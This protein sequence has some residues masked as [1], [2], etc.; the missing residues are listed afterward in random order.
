MVLQFVLIVCLAQTPAAASQLNEA[1]RLFAL[2]DVDA[3]LALTNRVIEID[4]K[5]RAAYSLRASLLERRSRYDDAA[6]DWT[7]VLELNPTDDYALKGRAR[8]H[9]KAGRVA[10]SLADF[11]AFVKQHPEQSRE[12][13][14]RGITCYYTGKFDEG[15]RQFESYQDFDSADF[16][17]A[18]WRFMCM[19]RSVGLEKARAEMLKIGDDRRVPLR[20][21]YELYLG[22]KS[23]DDVLSAAMKGDPDK[24]LRNRQL[25][26]AHLYLG[27]WFDLLDERAKALVHLNKATNDHPIDHYMWDVAR[28]HRDRLA[29]D[30]GPKR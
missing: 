9:F 13:W 1:R 19:V 30:K 16:E 7:K 10:D 28:V 26:Y 14:D 15:K 25:F 2:G 20:E 8:V 6:R 5:I 29:N 18:V 23:P 24:S 17:N 22:K 21:I 3:A 4:P 12:Q 11:D 27:I